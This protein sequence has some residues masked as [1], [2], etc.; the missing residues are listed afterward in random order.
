MRIDVLDGTNG[1]SDICQVT[2]YFPNNTYVGYHTLDKKSDA[3]HI[4]FVTETKSSM[5]SKDLSVIEQSKIDCVEKPFNSISIANVR[6]TKWS[7]IKI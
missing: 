7:H 5:S 3:T 1:V 2:T 6:T 4:F